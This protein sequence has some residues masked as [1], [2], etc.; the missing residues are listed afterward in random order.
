MSNG[1]LAEE[2]ALRGELYWIGPLIMGAM[3]LVLL[4]A[5][6]NVTVLQLSRAVTRQREMGIRLAVGAGRP[7]LLRML[8]TENL[9]LAIAA[10][11]LSGYVAF[12]AP[13]IFAKTLA[14]PDMPV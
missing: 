10:G 12:K 14:T 11:A 7:R 3:T 8:L 6:T 5:C 13:A 2:P 4:I 1:S 9:L